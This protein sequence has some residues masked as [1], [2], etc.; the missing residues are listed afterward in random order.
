MAL[1]S[2]LIHLPLRGPRTTPLSIAN[3]MG[4]PD[5]GSFDVVARHPREARTLT[6]DFETEGS[7]ADLFRDRHS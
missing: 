2:G 5:L 3:L 1:C 7:D 6:S 4:M